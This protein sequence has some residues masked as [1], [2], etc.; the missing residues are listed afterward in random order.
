[1]R[2]FI[3]ASALIGSV[4]V[5]AAAAQTA[6]PSAPPA[7]PSTPPAAAV[8]AAPPSAT[9]MPTTPRS[10]TRR[11]QGREIVAASALER[12][13]N[14]FTEGQAQSR[15]EDAGFTN[16]SGLTKDDAGFWRARA[17]RNGAAVEVAMDFRG[18]IAAGPEVTSLPR[19]AAPAAPRTGTSPAP[20]PAPR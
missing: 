6:A 3:I 7:T 4:G 17:M 9:P 1:M 10:E 16:V 19:D 11:E 12:G 15:F 8:P 14:S 20:A 2:T 18:R 13:A 5:G